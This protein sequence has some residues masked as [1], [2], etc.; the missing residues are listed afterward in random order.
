VVVEG[1]LPEYSLHTPKHEKRFVLTHKSSLHDNKHGLDLLISSLEGE[2]REK[3][4]K[5]KRKK[6]KKK[7]KRKKKKRKRQRKKKKN[8]TE[9]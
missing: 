3:K 5:R 9:Q 2:A 7:K 4:K 8:R 1:Q 6:K